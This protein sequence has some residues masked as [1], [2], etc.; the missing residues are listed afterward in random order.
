MALWGPR[1]GAKKWILLLFAVGVGTF[2]V[3]AGAADPPA[4][5]T[6]PPDVTA[7]ATSSAGATVSYT[8]PSATDDGGA[9]TPTVSCNPDTG[10][11][12]PLGTTPVTCTATDPVDSTQATVSFNVTVQDTTAPSLTQVPSNMSV[13]GNTTGGAT[14]SW[15]AS[16]TDTVD[17]SVPVNCS[18]SSGSTF[19]LGTTNVSC[20]ATDSH[21]NTSAAATFTVTVVDTTPP[22]LN[23]PG[24]ITAEATSS[25]GATVG[26][27]A[28]ASD[29]V[30][31]SPGVSCNPASGSAFP[32]GS[33]TVNCT[34]TDAS[35]KQATGSFAV[36]VVDTTP[37]TISNVPGG[38][39]VE[40]NGPGG[41]IATYSSPAASDSVDGPV[42]VL[43]SPVSGSNFPLG[44]TTVTCAASDAQHNV[45]STTFTVNVVDTTP[46]ALSIPAPLVVS[47]TSSAG[48]AMPCGSVSG[49]LASATAQDLIDPHPKLSWTGLA[50]EIPIGVNTVTFAATD[51]SGNRVTRTSTVTVELVQGTSS[52]PVTPLPPVKPPQ[53]VSG[54]SAASGDSFVLVRWKNPTGTDFDHVGVYRS[55]PTDSGVGKEIYAGPGTQFRDTGLTNDVQYRYVIV[56]FDR[57]GNRSV[58]IVILATP[59]VPKLV[60]P[61]DG[62]RVRRPPTLRWVSAQD[63]NYYNVQLFRDTRTA[64]SNS[65]ATT[66][67]RIL[68]AWP[69]STR[70]TLRKRWRYKGH[71]YHLTPGIYRWFVWPGYGSP[72]QNKY[73]LMLGQSIFIVT[74]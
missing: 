14:V 44:A 65:F 25:A 33:T 56:T 8:V 60:A 62:V 59:S 47:T 22:T 61:A 21:G 11:T 74:K 10:S 5:T 49:W 13:E 6:T 18:S 4:F 67:T 1:G 30:D 15:T 70:L 58:G 69:V 7:E 12:F 52:P 43:C 9:N 55:S 20:T 66:A 48:C 73:G 53:N 29:I 45:A 68:S 54:V 64:L 35:G 2:F 3:P 24:T 38:V 39:S 50:D 41:S 16:A 31:A 51:A 36:N 19:P 42:P 63:A 71:T 46:P 72:S 32:I 37:P 57:A 27:S 28:T 23:L 34:A 26:F 17:G 40:A